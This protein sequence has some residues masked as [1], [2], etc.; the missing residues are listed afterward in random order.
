MKL[1]IAEKPELAK[2]I[3]TAIQGDEISK[4]GYIEKGDYA[5]TWAFGH[6]L[7]LKDPDDYDNKYKKWSVEH[8]PLYFKNWE[9]KISCAEKDEYKAKQLRV[10][11][12]LLNRCDE[13]IHGGDP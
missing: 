3:A 5:V 11:E 2:A 13:V 4:N 9:H 7:Q 1:I 8:L 6:M 10:I 12:E